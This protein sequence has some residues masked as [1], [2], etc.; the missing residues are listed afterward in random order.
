MDSSKAAQQEKGGAA[1]SA[2]NLTHDA[3]L[4]CSAGAGGGVV[5]GDPDGQRDKENQG[6]NEG[7]PGQNGTKGGIVG[8]RVGREGA[9]A[10]SGAGEKDHEQQPQLTAAPTGTAAAAAAI[11]KIPAWQW[12]VGG[13]ACASIVVFGT[14][15]KTVGVPEFVSTTK[16]VGCASR[17]GVRACVN[18]GESNTP[19][20]N[21][22][23]QG[24]VTMASAAV[25]A[26][27]AGER[28]FVNTSESAAS[29]VSAAAAANLYASMVVN[30]PVVR[31]VAGRGFVNTAGS[32]T[33]ASRVGVVGFVITVS[34]ARIVKSVG[35]AVS[36]NMVVSDTIA[37]TVMV[38]AGR[39]V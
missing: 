29:A 11:K 28:T 12:S 25:S 14:D 2:D 10:D 18:T 9:L 17:V 33:F 8:K 1:L 32:V 15:A 4:A 20:G 19:A 5:S 36:A 37:E 7:E 31:N 30:A 3:L 24:Y 23:V 6:G 39:E 16:S 13:L 27:N 34:S 38:Q 26:R 35:E 21:V 22:G